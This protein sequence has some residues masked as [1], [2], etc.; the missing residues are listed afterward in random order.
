MKETQFVWAEVK[1]TLKD[2]NVLTING[3]EYGFIY[4]LGHESFWCVH[5]GIGD[6]TRFL[7]HAETKEWGKMAL[8]DFYLQRD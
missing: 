2:L 7:G 1:N 8:K 6:K 4:R 5:V 3:Y